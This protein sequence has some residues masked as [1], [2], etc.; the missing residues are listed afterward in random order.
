MALRI[1][2]PYL[3]LTCDFSKFVITKR[4]DKQ[5]FKMKKLYINKNIDILDD[6]I[7]DY[8]QKLIKEGKTK[9]YAVICALLLRQKVTGVS[10]KGRYVNFKLDNKETVKVNLTTPDLIEHQEEI[11]DLIVNAYKAERE[12]TMQNLLQQEKKIIVFSQSTSPYTSSYEKRQNSYQF[13]INTGQRAQDY[14]LSD[15]KFVINS[16]NAILENMEEEVT[17]RDYRDIYDENRTNSI[18]TLETKDTTILLDNLNYL[19]SSIISTVV[20]HNEAIE[21]VLKNK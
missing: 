1:Y 2:E 19:S 9:S 11:T 21:K 14:N 8:Y 10:L 7:L 4:K 18:A 20:D 17:V 16:V 6:P 15:K 13:N 5:V 3:A 12:R